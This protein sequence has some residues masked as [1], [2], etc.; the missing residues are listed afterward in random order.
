LSEISTASPPRAFVF[1]SLFHGKTS[2]WPP[3]FEGSCKEDI[4]AKKMDMLYPAPAVFLISPLQTNK[5]FFRPAIQK[6]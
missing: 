3:I 6:P 5:P 4:M 2:A 1:F